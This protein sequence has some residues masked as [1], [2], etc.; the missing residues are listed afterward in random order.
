MTRLALVYP[1]QGSQKPGMGL[2]WRDTDSW[3][4][5]E[6]ASTAS[7]VDV[8]TLLCTADAEQ[9]KDTQ[10]SQ[11]ATLT[12]SLMALDHA[13]RADLF[14]DCEIVGHAGH[15]LGEYSALAAARALPFTDVVRLVAERGAAMRGAATDEPGG[16][17]AIVGIA[18]DSLEHMVSGI[19][20]CW[21]ANDNGAEQYVVS[22]RPESVLRLANLAR[23]AKANLVSMLPVAGAFHSPLMANASTHL[24][25]ALK[26]TEFRSSREP[27][28]SS[29]D[30]SPH[31]DPGDFPGLLLQQLVAP[32]CWRQVYANLADRSDV[33]I[34]VG[35]GRVLTRLGRR[36]HPGLSQITLNQP[37]DLAKILVRL[38]P[39]HG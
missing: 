38:S 7:G 4:I 9:L 39:A 18:A 11:L 28:F 6:M 37:S 19:E 13:R 10:H 25:D 20:D 21:I 30:A 14:E 1:G 26:N 23:D 32:V 22:G 36:D 33:I 5:A 27:I 12:T 8:P 34:E 35:P 24:A 15:S 16:M 31:T 2:P 29:V 3:R 17:A